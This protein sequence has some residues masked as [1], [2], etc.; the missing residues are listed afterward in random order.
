M[1]EE[2]ITKHGPAWVGVW[3]PQPAPLL[4]T[5]VVTPAAYTGGSIQTTQTSWS[6]DR[7]DG[8]QHGLQR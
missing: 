8:H 5:G 6:S 2:P 7:A 3:R 4:A 1:K